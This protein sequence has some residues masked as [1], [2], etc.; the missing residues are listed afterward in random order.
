MGL[1]E[2]GARALTP[3]VSSYVARQISCEARTPHQTQMLP[4]SV[5]PEE[6]NGSGKFGTNAKT[7]GGAVALA[8]SPPTV[9]T[10]EP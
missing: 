9:R 7:M 8:L 1:P 3:V 5:A 10:S 6:R 4:R 2:R